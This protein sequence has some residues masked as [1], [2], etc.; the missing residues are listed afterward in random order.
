MLHAQGSFPTY[1]YC[2]Q[3]SDGSSLDCSYSTLSMCYQSV[4]GVGGTCINN[5]R[6]VGT[7]STNN[8]QFAFGPVP[9]SPPPQS[10][11]PLQLP[12]ASPSSGFSPAANAPPPP[13]SC[14]PVIDGTYCATA[15]SNSFAPIQS[16]SSDLSGGGNPPATL[17][18]INFSG[19]G[20]TCIGLFR[21]TSC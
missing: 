7:A 20:L 11:G 8:S 2:A 5:P 6:A 14:N 3:Y 9:I 13:Q 16:L 12:G 15:A 21:R 10:Q 18:A 17:G 1:P 4:T 19:S